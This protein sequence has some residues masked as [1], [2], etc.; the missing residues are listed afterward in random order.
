[1]RKLVAEVVR[2]SLA[3]SAQELLRCDAM[4]RLDRGP[5]GV[6][7]AR[8]AVRRMRSDLRSFEP[9][10]EV[11][12][13]ATLREEMRWLGDAL[14]TVR[15]AD[16]LLARLERDLDELPGPDRASAYLVLTS[17]RS[18][19]DDAYAQLGTILHEARYAELLAKIVGAGRHPVL[20]ARAGESA[21]DAL[22]DVMRASWKRLRSS[23]RKRSRPPS[24]TELHEI[25]IRAKRVR[26]AAEAAEIA[27]GK[28][29]ARFARRV[30]RLQN[31]LGEQHDAVATEAAL[32]ALVGGPYALMAGAL[33]LVEAACAAKA[34]KRWHDAWR[35]IN[36]PG[37]RFWER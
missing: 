15:D 31:V 11:P 30:K 26:Y 21:R 28:P 27:C 35:R 9:F 25:R 8:L 24:D 37:A 2:A 6:H 29:A 20:G 7:G 1:M 19:R 22:A 36:A 13:A 17:F 18:A 3:G 32:R 14:G 5:D 33:I 4:L 16:I 23:V 12:W 10:L 34:R